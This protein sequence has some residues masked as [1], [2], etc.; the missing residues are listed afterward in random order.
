MKK[1]SEF[2]VQRH[3]CLKKIIMELKISLLIVLVSVSNVFATRSYSQV[4][5]ISLK[6]ENKPLELVM[7]EIE[8]Q[9]E[10]Y[11]IFNQKQIDVNRT[12]SV[13]E[14]NKQIN[15]VLKDIFNG[16]NVYYAVLDRKILLS[17]EPLENET[18]LLSLSQALQ[19][20]QITGKIT[21]AATGEAM[22]GVNIQVKGTSIGAITDVD[23][24]F[25]L[26][27]SV[28]KNSTLIIT[29]IGYQKMEVP[30]DGKFQVNIQLTPDMTVIDEV[31]VVGYGTVKKETLTGS[32]T[33]IKAAD[34]ITTKSEN[35]I[36]NIQGKVSG[37][38]VRQLTGEPGKFNNYVS[39]RGFG[40]PLVVID[41]VPRDGTADMA[42]LNPNDIESM[43]VL[44][45]AA[46]SIYGMNAA[47]GVI[48]ITTKKG[49]EG[50][51]QFSYSNLFGVKG[52]TGIERTVDAYT[53]RVMKNE[54]DRNS[55]TNESFTSDILEKYR[56]NQPGY[57]D[58]NW[59]DLCLKPW[60][61]QQSHNLS[62]KGGTKA[63]Q[64]FN[65]FGYTEDNGLLQ[66]GMQYYHRY[67]FRST[68]S[69]ELSKSFKLNVSLSGR[70]D[71]R[72]T[73]R[74][75]F[76]WTYKT[77][78]VNDRGIN[79]HTMANPDHL[80]VIQP[81]SKN[82]WA[83]MNPDLDGYNRLKELF[84][85]STIDLTYTSQKIAGL[86]AS[87][88]TAFDE[89][90]SNS[91]FLQRSY[92]LYDYYTDAFSQ[93]TG[94]D[95]YQSTLQLGQRTVARA[96]VNYSKTIEKHKFSLTGVTEYRGTRSDIVMAKRLYSD[97]FTHDIIDQGTSTTSSNSGNRGFGK[98]AAYIGRANYDYAGK[99]LLEV[100]ARYD[101]SYRYSMAKRWAFFPSASLGWRISEESFIKDNIPAIS[102]LKLRFSYG[103]S[104]TDAGSAFSYYSAYTAS[105]S[106]GYV[107]NDG[108]LT[109]GMVAPGVVSDQMS[110]VTSKIT[111]LAL[112]A[113]L[114]KG[115]LSGTIELFNRKNDGVLASLIQSVPNTFG[116]SLPQQNVNSNRNIGFEVLISHRN[117]IGDINYGVS[118]NFTY[119]RYENLHIENSGY[120]SSWN[121]WRNSTTNRYTGSMA[122]YEWDGRY[123]DITQY[124][125]APLM[126]GSAGNS[127]MLPGSYK[128]VDV[129]GD[130]IINSSDQTYNHWTYGA[131]N[132]PMQYGLTL[133]ASYK[134]FD[135]NILF[136]GASGYCINYRNND[137]WG[138]GRYP[139][140]HEKFLDRWH[141]VNT[142]DNPYNPSTEWTDG[143]YPALRNYN[144]D[145][146]TE[147]NVIDI[148]RPDATYL[149]LKSLEIGYT[150]PKALASKLGMNN[151]RVFVNGYNLLTICNKL[152][153][154]A[155]PE[156]Q[157]ADWDAN[158]AY[159]LMKSFNFGFSINF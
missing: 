38:M 37:L 148:W 62:V 137:I 41:G 157:E 61:F 74:E 124:E 71:D 123:S 58:V 91:S 82:A 4:A 28:D 97:L 84:F 78:M 9:S 144:Y 146:T 36:S 117:K 93:T 30:V 155:D 3:S 86:T 49:S 152:L 1:N 139:T 134:G 105:A 7:D 92:N 70:F 133:D 131:V 47:N 33:N 45:D 53:Y 98:Y 35:L 63:V 138:Y 149:R 2:G 31:V 106:S 159:P 67:N 40:T 8:K 81:E 156:R 154:N 111:N 59:I 99:Y 15:D 16:T 102:N 128:L 100:V 60:V 48:I 112:D 68:T 158:L 122:L 121:Y 22:I 114:W 109:V 10:F 145:N 90:I 39:I 88:T 64:Y 51:A 32:V 21:D 42:Q 94:S 113:E 110:W 89:N 23:G 13:S 140:L 153:K 43:S 119:A 95:Q 57:Q 65:S 17:T 151:G 125:T 20:Q 118:A 79:Y 83:L 143:F 130:G 54:M 25:S 101:G 6:M 150:F 34:I 73:P 46:A 14:E 56:T 29:F 76:L 80:T 120:S 135:I 104:G 107:F 127:K 66:T 87:F 26:P 11:F 115:K 141:T 69:A 19:Q 129:N 24:K 103:E 5:K 12:V 108:A 126:G 72:Q 52:A 147:A 116:A 85:Q 96:Q 55:G 136:Q 77:I 132:P 18:K 27:A 44:K 75:D 142:T 50:K